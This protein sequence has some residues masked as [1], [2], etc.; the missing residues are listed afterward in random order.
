[1]GG[2]ARRRGRRRRLRRQVGKHGMIIDFADEA[3]AALSA[4]YL[5]YVCSEQ[6][7]ESGWEG[8]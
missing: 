7:P 6:G 5:P 4:T 2:D 3:G 8:E 1:M